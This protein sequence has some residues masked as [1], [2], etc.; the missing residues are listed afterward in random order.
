MSEDWF[1]K[2]AQKLQQLINS[3]ELDPD[4]AFDHWDSTEDVSSAS[5]NYAQFKKWMYKVVGDTD[6]STEGR[7]PL[8]RLVNGNEEVWVP[9]PVATPKAY[10]SCAKRYGFDYFLSKK[11]SQLLDVLNDAQSRWPVRADVLLAR[12][13]TNW[14]SRR[15]TYLRR[16]SGEQKTSRGPGRAGATALAG[17]RLSYSDQSASASPS[18]VSH[19]GQNLKNIDSAAFFSPGARRGAPVPRPKV[20][21]A[22]EAKVNENKTAHA[23]NG[24]PDHPVDNTVFPA[25]VAPPEGWKVAYIARNDSGKEVEALWCRTSGKFSSVPGY[26]ELFA[27]EG[28]RVIKANRMLDDGW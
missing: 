2:S 3:L 22:A 16:K 18:F 21:P 13:H 27:G 11:A 24:Y 7:K 8:T 5:A 20:K 28:D 25:G 23:F 9:L 26:I 14:R 4:E 12:I 1:T 17:R 6:M 15:K 19:S 10:E